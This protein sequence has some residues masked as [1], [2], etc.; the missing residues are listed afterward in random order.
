MSR[1]DWYLSLSACRL[2]IRNIWQKRWK[3]SFVGILFIKEAIQESS[4]LVFIVQYFKLWGNWKRPASWNIGNRRS[5]L[6]NY[7]IIT[8]L[9]YVLNTFLPQMHASWACK[10]ETVGQS[11]GQ[12][13]S[14]HGVFYSALLSDHTG[15][16]DWL[17][18][19]AAIYLVL[20]VWNQ[21]VSVLHIVHKFYAH[22][23]VPLSDISSTSL[24]RGIIRTWRMGLILVWN[25]FCTSTIQYLLNFDSESARI[26]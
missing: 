24:I 8:C 20:H 13:H 25:H 19:Y 12:L 23:A 14:N 2:F 9:V 16:G 5:S 11:K 10:P 18:C 1:L 21:Q 15:I 4:A 17:A 22:F 3:P 26:K 7:D 6:G